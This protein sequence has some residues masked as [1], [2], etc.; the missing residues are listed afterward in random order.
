[1]IKVVGIGAGGKTLTLEAIEAIKKAEVIIGYSRYIEMIRGYIENA[2]II[3][4]NVNEI[5]QRIDDSLKFSNK[6][7]IV[8]SSGDPMIYGM[9][10]RLFKYNV[11]IIP[12]VTAA[13]LASSVAKVP[14]DDFVT[15]S[16]STYSRSLKEIEN[17]LINAIN[18]NFTLVIYNINPV[19]RKESALLAENTLKKYAIDWDYYMVYNARRANQRL[20]HGKIN[21][22]D[23]KNANM[24]TILMVKKW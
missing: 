24:D 8:I 13:S 16:L 6:N 20:I 23:I 7:T 2:E 17:K 18:G 11:E 22:L 21:S 3:S 10:S 4:S 5:G 19:A 1:M 14:L 15:I 9:G 12:G